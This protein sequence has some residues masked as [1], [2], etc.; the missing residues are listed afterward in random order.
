M[1]LNRKKSSEKLEGDALHFNLFVEEQTGGFTEF[2]GGFRGVVMASA[3]LREALLHFGMT[4]KIVLK[5]GSD[6]FALRNDGHPCWD[7][8]LDFVKKQRIVG[9][10]KNDGIDVRILCHEFLDAIL[11]EIISTRFVKFAVFNERNPHRT[12]QSC[13]TVTWVEL[14]DFELVA[15]ALDGT[16]RGKHSNVVVARDVADDFS[17]WDDDSQ[18]S[19]VGCMLREIVL[20]NGTQCLGGSGVATEDDERTSH[21]EKFLHGLEGEFIDYIEGTC[22]VWGTRIVAQV[23][24]VVLGKA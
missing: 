17:G 7:V 23:D 10:T 22:S 9:A 2:G 19:T 14:L 1:T 13:D 3:S 24:V 12:R 11:H 5:A 21:L 18:H 8:F 6:V 4:E 20:L 15:F 16:L